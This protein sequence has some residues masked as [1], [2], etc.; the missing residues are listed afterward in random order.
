MRALEQGV[1]PGLAVLLFAGCA[2]TSETKKPLPEPVLY[3]WYGD[4][5]QGPVAITIHKSTQTAEITIGGE[6]AGWTMVATGKAGYETP[7]R[8]YKVIEKLE[9]KHSSHYGWM[10][11]A[12]GEVIDY[13]ADS[14]KDRPPPGGKFEHA[15]MPYWMR[16]TKYGI[17]LHAGIIPNPGSPASKGCIRLP[18]TLAPILFERVQLGTPVRIV[19]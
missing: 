8:L 4:H 11:D 14:R 9:E 2:A 15:P 3:E 13:D 19:D 17:G 6:P 7:S 1:I 5:L 12:N 16:L 10:V 18:K